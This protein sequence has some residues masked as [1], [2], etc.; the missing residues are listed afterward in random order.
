MLLTYEPF[1][2]VA[3]ARTGVVDHSSSDA[4]FF[5]DEKAVNGEEKGDSGVEPQDSEGNVVEDESS[6]SNC[7]YDKSK[8]FFDNISCDDRYFI[9]SRSCFDL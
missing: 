4:S 5:A 2:L 8:S 9:Q 1:G 7:Y 6:G 3:V